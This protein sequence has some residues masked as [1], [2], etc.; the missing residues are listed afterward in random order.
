MALVIGIDDAGRGPLIGPMIL[1][2]V[3]LD[4]NSE[5]GLKK[6]G[7]RD[8]KQVLHPKR[9]ELAKIIKETVLSYHITKT[10]PEQIDKMISEG[11][12]LNTI[13]AIKTAE[14]INELNDEKQKGKIKVII[15]CPSVNTKAWLGTLKKYI[16]NISNLILA[17]EHKAD[18]N[19]VAVSAASIIAKVAREE[20]VSKLREQYKEYGNIGS[21]YPADPLTKEFL[22]KQGKQLENSGLFRKSWK[23][24][25]RL[26]PE[27]KKQSTLSAF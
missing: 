5:A 19:Y 3:L 10:F 26:Y 14:I 12:N 4:E 21:G 23:T 11:T 27:S 22:K 7:V 6:L 24:W 1:A 16:K 8:S 20:E 13:E 18:V 2:G 25:K 17:C 9:V 15:D